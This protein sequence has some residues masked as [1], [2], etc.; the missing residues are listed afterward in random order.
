M[1]TYSYVCEDCSNNFELFFHIKDYISQPKCSSCG[2]KKTSR[3]Y[4][5]D[6]QTQMSSVKKS[7]SE[8]K[9][10]GDLALR[11][12]ERFSDDQKIHLHQKHNQYREDGPQKELPRGMSRIKKQPKIKWPGSQGKTKRK[13]S[14]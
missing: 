5:K 7:D 2:S 4:I 14:R 13:P 9:T 6:V 10:I 11:N 1:P 3:E 8:L 12:S